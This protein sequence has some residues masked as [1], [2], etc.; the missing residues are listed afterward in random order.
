MTTHHTSE[1]VTGIAESLGV[2]ID[3]N[4]ARIDPE[5][6]TRRR[7]KQART[8]LWH[9]TCPSEYRES[10]WNHPRLAPWKAQI[11]RVLAWQ[12]V[13]GGKGL[14]LSGPTGRGKTRSLWALLKRLQC[15]D[16][17]DVGVWK[18]VDWFAALSRHLNY[19]RDDAAGFVRACAQRTILVIDDLGQEA[20][21]R[22]REGWSRAWF[23]D[24]LDTRLS[25]GRHTLITT[26]LSANRIAGDGAGDDIRGEP[27][28]R[29]LIE[30]CEVVHFSTAAERVAKT[31]G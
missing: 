13:Q 30:L 19:G 12:P 22:S 14:L 26:N 17:R 27:L 18:A 16:A 10:D 6:D 21:D 20:V 23:F 1:L 28:V 24:L 11:E 9:R 31:K 8:E 4:M 3:P 2:T 5:E 25:E 7:I 29:R 15:D